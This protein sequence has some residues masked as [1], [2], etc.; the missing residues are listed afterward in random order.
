MQTENQRIV[1]GVIV[2]GYRGVW[3]TKQ[4]KEEKK[5]KQNF[6][7]SWGNQQ[8][9]QLNKYFIEVAIIH[10]FAFLKNFCKYINKEQFDKFINQKKRFSMVA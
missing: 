1:I 7:L 3:L 6:L 8:Q 4:R 2:T 10:L 9:L 5:D